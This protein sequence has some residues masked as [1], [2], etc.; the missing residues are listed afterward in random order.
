[1]RSQQKIKEMMAE[2]KGVDQRNE[3]VRNIAKRLKTTEETK[4]EPA[5]LRSSDE[6][7][8]TTAKITSTENSSKERVPPLA[9]KEQ[10]PMERHSCVDETREEQGK[11]QID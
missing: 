5:A 6:P 8:A 10:S 7:K 11:V 2:V 9:L 3:T 4:I 1:M